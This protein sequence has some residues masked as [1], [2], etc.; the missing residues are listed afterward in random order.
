MRIDKHSEGRQASCFLDRI[1][2]SETPSRGTVLHI[3]HAVVLGAP[4]DAAP[5]GISQSPRA[6]QTQRRTT[7]V[8]YSYD[9]YLS[10]HRVLVSFHV[11]KDVYFLF[12]VP[13]RLCTDPL[14]FDDGARKKRLTTARGPRQLRIR[15]T[16]LVQHFRPTTGSRQNVKGAFDIPYV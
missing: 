15:A 13:P 8:G 12:C 7:I 10:W 5:P 14:R 11:S 2:V 4:R 1:A 9:K 3:Q 16:L 6:T